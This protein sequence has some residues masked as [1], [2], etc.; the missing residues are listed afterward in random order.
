[1]LSGFILRPRRHGGFT[2]I[3]LLVVIAIIAILIGLLLPAVQKVR[4]AAARSTCQNNLKQM[5][6]AIHNFESTNQRI[7][8]LLGGWGS[9]KFNLIWGPPH[10][11]LL[12]FVEQDPLYK[13]MYNTGNANQTY[14][15]WGGIN[16][17]NP[18]SKIVKPY[19]CPSDN[20][21]SSGLNQRTG[22]GGTSYSANAQLFAQTDVNGV[23][24]NWDRGTN[25]ANIRDGSSNTM[26][27]IEKIGDCNP[28]SSG[29]AGGGSL[30]GVQWDP[31]YP[32]VLANATNPSQPYLITDANILPLFQPTQN[33]CDNRRASSMHSQVIQISLADGS[34]RNVRSSITMATWWQAAKPDD[35]MVLGSDWN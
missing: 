2:L 10:V 18:Y 4:E 22:W 35:G 32:M 12:P 5:T 3:E 31:W 11:F 27:F 30:W 6:L 24:Q 7:P 19:T 23:M 21:L 8:P 26:A 13:D 16:N 15:W 1:M 29:S 14:A 25:I 34:V 28:G 17:D 20:S 9:T 33:T